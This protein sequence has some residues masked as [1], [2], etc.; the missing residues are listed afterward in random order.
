M[1][2]QQTLPEIADQRTL[3]D[4]IDDCDAADSVPKTQAALLDRAQTHAADVAA[5]HFPEFPV[6][7]IDWEVSERTQRQAGVTEY[8][9]DTEAVT[10][11]FTWDA[12]QEFG[13]IQF[14][15]TV[16]HELVHAWQ[17]W[18]FKEADHGE[19]FAH[20]MDSFNID[21]HCERFTSRLIAT[22]ISLITNTV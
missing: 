22:T 15:K 3:T 1:T 19:T 20:W 6:E 17:Y 8:D 18:Q 14:S 7:S 4:S 16:W 2:R 13:W 9:P 10:I 5:E 11:R 21:Q 12:Y